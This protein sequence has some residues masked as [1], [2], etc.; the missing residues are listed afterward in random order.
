MRP[1]RPTLAARRHRAAAALG[2]LLEPTGAVLLVGAGEPTAVP[3]GLDRVHPFDTHPHYFWLTGGVA[4]GGVIAWDPTGDGWSWFEPPVGEGERVWE[5]VRGEREGE[6]INGLAGWLTARRGRPVVMLGSPLPGVVSDAAIDRDADERLLHARRAKDGWELAAIRRASEITRAG[7]RR[8]QEMIAAGGVTERE[9]AIELDHAFRVAGGDG[10]GYDTIVGVGPDAAVLHFTP[11]ERSVNAG[12]TVLVD[13]GG[14]LDRYTG[15]VTR[16]YPCGPV[17][18]GAKALIQLVERVQAV[19]VAGC[20]V[21][22]EFSELHD[23]AVLVLLAGLGEIG[24]VRGDPE[25][26]I[27]RGVGRLFMPHGL[28]H[29]VGLG[30]RDATGTTPGRAHRVS[31]SGVC[32]RL[33]AALDTNWVVTVEPGCYFV[34]A[35]L[36]LAA[37]DFGDAVDFNAVRALNKDIS[38]VRIEDNVVVHRSDAF[39][40][41][42]EIP[43]LTDTQHLS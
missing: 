26:L 15:D 43:K 21:G 28:G 22:V 4:A 25:D 37:A 41:T 1:D 12:E 5:G 20:V 31:R 23:Q 8:A 29:L 30:V 2:P 40:L 18:D 17:S 7:H 16:V 27:D 3:G 34:P 10:P 36:E 24:L 6:P 13:A 32:V 14:S 11:G 42:R 33:D 35:L 19:A 39:N 9:I 38:G